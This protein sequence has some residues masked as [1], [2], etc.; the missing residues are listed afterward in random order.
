MNKLSDA[1]LAVLLELTHRCPLRCAYCSNPLEMVKA[2]EELPTEAWQQAIREAA[3]LG[4]HQVHFS[5]GEP[6]ARSDLDVLVRTA[7]RH[8]LYGNLITSGVMLDAARLAALVEAGPDPDRD[9]VVRWRR[10][11][12]K[13]K[14]EATFGVAYHERTVGKLLAGLGYVHISVRPQHPDTDIAAQEAFKKTFAP[15]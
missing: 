14:I 3:K 8:G 1:P 6:M 13:R 4:M 5:G 15:A 9:G 2:R 12:L 10:I 11:D 7:S